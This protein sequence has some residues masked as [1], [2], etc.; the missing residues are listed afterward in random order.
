MYP[1]VFGPL[2]WDFLHIAT[3]VYPEDPTTERQ[4]ALRGFLL[5]MCLNLPCPGCSSHCQTYVSEN[6]PT[7]ESRQSA[8]QY[9][10]NFHNDVNER[11]GKR[12]WTMEESDKYIREKY[13]DRKEWSNI[14]RSMVVRQE[15]DSLIKH[16]QT[17]LQTS[18]KLTDRDWLDYTV[19]GC[20]LALLVL[21]SIQLIKTRTNK[22]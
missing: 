19:L 3:M 10:L 8:K 7:V 22:A 21:V 20:L 5:N 13:F 11:T 4:A 2:L 1:P 14:Q 18:T 16:Y 9:I 12:Q 6:P 15:T 17:L